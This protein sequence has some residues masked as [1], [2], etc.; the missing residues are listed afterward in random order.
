MFFKVQ[1]LCNRILF[2]NNERQKQ[3]FLAVLYVNSGL[4]IFLLKFIK[5]VSK[6]LNVTTTVIGVKTVF[7]NI[8]RI[9]VY[10]LFLNM[11]VLVFY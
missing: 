11:V 5:S 10:N 3:Y 2:I 8:F 9:N 4:Y 6:F 1:Q 7:Y